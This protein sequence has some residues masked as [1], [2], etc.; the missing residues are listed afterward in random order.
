ML[1]P[2]LLLC[3]SHVKLQSLEDR[4]SLAEKIDTRYQYWL[5]L[6]TAA[7]SKV[8]E[9]KRELRRLRKLEK[10]HARGIV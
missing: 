10:L 2:Y 1:T 7:E 6:T 4:I 8:M 5:E 3:C 9:L